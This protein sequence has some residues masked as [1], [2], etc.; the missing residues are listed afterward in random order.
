MT[1]FISF[2]NDAIASVKTSSL[3]FSFSFTLAVKWRKNMNKLNSGRLS[4]I[5]FVSSRTRRS[6]V[7]LLFDFNS[8]LNYRVTLL[9]AKWWLGS[10][11]RIMIISYHSWG[12]R[13]ESIAALTFWRFVEFTTWKVSSIFTRQNRISQIRKFSIST[14]PRWGAHKIRQRFLLSCIVTLDPAWDYQTMGTM[15]VTLVYLIFD[16]KN[17]KHRCARLP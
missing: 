10:V 14:H 8:F 11:R 12:Y 13:V 2:L 7:L 3:F 1:S 4:E 15:K 16:T 6:F 5:N 9:V 17:R